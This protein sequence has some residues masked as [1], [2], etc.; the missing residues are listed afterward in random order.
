MPGPVGEPLNVYS[1]NAFH[2]EIAGIRRAA[3]SECSEL[4]VEVAV[5]TYFEGGRDIPHKKPSRRTFP[6]VTLSR[7]ATGDGEFYDWLEQVASFADGLGQVGDTYKRT[8]DIVE[9]DAD[10]SEVRR[11]TLHGCFPVKLT[12]GDWNADSDDA[13]VESVTLAYDFFERA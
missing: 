5:Q 13:Q 7:G 11:H 4:A 9:L 6:D 2:V 3:F 8:M 12:V 10:G 1:K